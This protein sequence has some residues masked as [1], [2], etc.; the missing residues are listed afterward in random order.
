VNPAAVAPQV[1]RAVEEVLKTVPVEKVTTLSEQ[2]DSSL[3]LERVVA[4]LSGSF[5]TLG[6]CLAAIGL[7]GLLAYTVTRRTNEIGVRMALGAT[8]GDVSRMVL[9]GAFG[10]VVAGL[11]VGVPL[12]IAGQRFAATL[13]QGLPVKT[14]I[15]IAV[16]SV[17]MIGIACLAAYIPARRAA[18]VDPL[19][20]LRCD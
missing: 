6:A 16:A 2:V 14:V 8:A 10:L 12:A 20:A 19:L 1:R 9:T 11:V 18:R 17:T 13:V 4:M 7:Y 5:G 3:V 15:P